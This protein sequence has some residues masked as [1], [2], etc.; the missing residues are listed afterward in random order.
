MGKKCVFETFVT[1]LPVTLDVYFY[2]EKKTF[3]HPSPF[4]SFKS[5]KV[6]SGAFLRP[7]LFKCRCLSVKATQTLTPYCQ[8]IGSEK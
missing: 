2:S 5:D 7:I 6:L 1:S 3:A 8:E 4:N